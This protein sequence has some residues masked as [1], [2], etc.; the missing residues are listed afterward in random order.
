MYNLKGKIDKVSNRVLRG[1]G[2][3][4]NTNNLQSWNRNNNNPNNTNNNNGF[5]CSNTHTIRMCKR[6]FT[7]YIFL[8]PD[9]F[10]LLT[11]KMNKQKPVSNENESWFL[12]RRYIPLS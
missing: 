8:S 3:N 10:L 4:N 7:E 12:T 6:D 11:A 1:G 2:W 9:F 5:R